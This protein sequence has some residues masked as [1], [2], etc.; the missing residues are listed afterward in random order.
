MW[1]Q[2][3]RVIGA[4]TMAKG[5]REI[6]FGGGEIV[7]PVPKGRTEIATSLPISPESRSPC[8]SCVCLC[9]LRVILAAWRSGRER[10]GAGGLILCPPPSLILSPHVRRVGGYGCGCNQLIRWSVTLGRRTD[11]AARG[12]RDAAAQAHEV[13]CCWPHTGARGRTRRQAHDLLRTC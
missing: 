10:E 3:R 1:H 9:V 12:A 2:C 4:S 8:R 6:G 5:R 11:A 7:I 13:T